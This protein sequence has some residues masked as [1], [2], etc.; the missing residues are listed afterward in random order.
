MSVTDTS[1]R[2]VL[3]HR[4]DL[5]P[6]A[7]VIFS[8]LVIPETCGGAGSP[9]AGTRLEVRVPASILHDTEAV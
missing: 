2:F 5:F 1:L 6:G 7:P 9:G 4:E 3:D 8:G